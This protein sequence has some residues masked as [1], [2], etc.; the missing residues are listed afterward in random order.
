MRSVLKPWSWR[1]P[2]GTCREGPGG[3]SRGLCQCHERPVHLKAWRRD[4]LSWEQTSAPRKDCGVAG[5][6]SLRCHPLKASVAVTPEGSGIEQT[7]VG[8]GAAADTGFAGD[9]GTLGPF[10]GSG[11]CVPVLVLMQGWG[12]GWIWGGERSLSPLPAK[13]VF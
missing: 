5:S 1:C 9:S 2:R 12:K 4:G 8:R 13:G 3:G 10:Q 7:P 11:H 6:L